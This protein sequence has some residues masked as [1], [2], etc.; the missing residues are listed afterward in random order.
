MMDYSATFNVE[1][2]E[3]AT[4]QQCISI[5]RH[6]GDTTVFKHHDTELTGHDV[7][8][9]STRTVFTDTSGRLLEK[10]HVIAMTPQLAIAE[11]MK[12]VIDRHA[13][14]LD[15]YPFQNED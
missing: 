4:G 12:V 3:D 8:R 14:Q 7:D 1:Y 10:P 9:F 13:A 6:A 15:P 5:T 11:A 2:Y